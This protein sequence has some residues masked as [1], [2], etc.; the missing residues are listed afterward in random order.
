MTVIEDKLNT[1]S[2]AMLVFDKI[3]EAGRPMSVKEI[4]QAAN[5]NKSSL[6]HHI[7]TLTELG[8]LQQDLQSR[9][10]DIGLRLVQAGQAYLQRMD[11]RERGHLYL[12]QLSLEL[13]QTSHMLILD[14]TKIVYVDKIEPPSHPGSLRCSSHVGMHT[15]IHSTASGKVL[16]SHVDNAAIEKTLEHL[17]FSPT[18]V[19]TIT[20][21]DHFRKELALTKERG[22]GLDLQEHSHGLQCVAVPVLNLNNECVAA[23]SVSSQV[24]LV[25]KAMLESEILEKLLETGQK[26]SAAMGYHASFNGRT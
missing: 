16:L 24:A 17:T 3:C 6:H 5:L 22:Y 15:D 4:A 26:I 1:V 2:K 25:D 23:I 12:E 14:G 11:V 20:D 21:I 8:Y 9:K 7:K 18:T 13:N 19:H 10:Y